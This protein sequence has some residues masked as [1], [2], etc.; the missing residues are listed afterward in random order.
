[1][2]FCELIR[3][4]AEAAKKEIGRLFSKQRSRPRAYASHV[5]TRP[6]R[7]SLVTVRVYSTVAQ[8]LLDSSAVPNLISP[9]LVSHLC[10]TPRPSKKRITVADG[11]NAPCNGVLLQVPT[12]F[13]ELTV[14]L[15]YLVVEGTPFD[16]IIGLPSLE[17]PQACIDV[18]K[19][20]V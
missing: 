1:M 11:G 2:T 15:D 10:L 18:G 12:S 19:Q 13:G 14:N 16:L 8:A 7:L 17:K 9:K 3:G 6:K 20:H 5:D 4:D